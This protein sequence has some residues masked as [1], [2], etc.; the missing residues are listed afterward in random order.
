MVQDG[1]LV[2]MMEWMAAEMKMKKVYKSE[3]PKD[4]SGLVWY[5]NMTTVPR[6]MPECGWQ[7]ENCATQDTQNN[8]LTISL[9]IV[10]V[11]FILAILVIVIYVERKQRYETNLKNISTIT[12]N[13]EDVQHN[14]RVKSTTS[15]STFGRG[16]NTKAEVYVY[17]DSP[18]VIEDLGAVSVNLQDRQ[19]LIDLKNMRD[20]THDNV[21]K[22]IGICPQSPNV[23]YLMAFASRGTLQDIIMDD[24]TS[25]SNDFKVSFI[26]DIACGMWY[27]HQSSIQVHGHLSSSAC[28]VDNRWTCKVTDYGLSYIKQ[29]YLKYTSSQNPEKLLW[30]APEILDNKS[31]PAHINL[32]TADV[33]SFAIIM[34]EIFIKNCPYGANDPELE[35][36]EIV[37][38][39]TARENPPYRPAM[40]PESC[41][42][43]WMQFIEECWADDPERRPNFD[44]ILVSINKIHRYKNMDLV[45]NMI[46]RLERHTRNL[47]DRVILRAREIET[48]RIKTEMLLGELLPPSVA[49]IL[50]SGHQ[51]EPDTFEC[52]TIYFSDIVSFTK[53]SAAATPMEIVVLLNNMYTMFDDISRQHDVYK[54]GTIGD[55]YMVASGLPI[56]NG[57]KHAYE[58]CCLALELLEASQGF[59]I[60]HMPGE[61]LQLRIGVHSGPCVAG[62]TGSK[63]PRYLLFG[64]TV[65]IAAKMESSGEPMKIQISETT[66]S[67]IKHERL[68]TEKRGDFLIKGIGN[69]TTFWLT[70]KI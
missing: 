39:V 59:P 19:V 25:L 61:H 8:V 69:M 38:K 10:G 22:F 29:K 3:D 55:A 46:K 64:D 36:Q 40:S 52:V 11:C 62:V 42:V 66:Q 70:E 41:S 65:D 43:K 28:V 58:I 68:V 13:W 49:S 37:Q 57:N 12:V 32:K 18:V 1:Q 35:S 31:D 56:R 53:I 60:P 48:E 30:T 14:V 45:D 51:V 44:K 6:D 15:F 27:L 7:G 17:N 16:E 4:W 21:N 26:L 20:T 33:F 34:S 5:G 9:S 47:E 50:A 54:V 2:T 23:C 63:M 67:L 24:D